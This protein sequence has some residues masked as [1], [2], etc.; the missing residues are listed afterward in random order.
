MQM[1]T[2]S[3]LSQQ[4]LRE[5]TQQS[6]GSVP[7]VEVALFEES[8]P[9]QR[10]E[11]KQPENEFHR[12]RRPPYERQSKRKRQVGHEF[13]ADRPGWIVPAE[14]FGLKTLQ[15]KNVCKERRNRLWSLQRDALQRAGHRPGHQL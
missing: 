1:A 14:F 8:E 11:K 7:L 5:A 4:K 10:A 9:T 2:A 6:D 12:M 3:P 15:H 13:H